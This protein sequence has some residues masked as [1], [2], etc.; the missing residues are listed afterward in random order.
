MSD[1][2]GTVPLFEVS[3]TGVRQPRQRPVSERAR[4]RWSRLKGAVTGLPRDDCMQ[5]YVE[6][7]PPPLLARRAVWRRALGAESRLLCNAHA[8]QWH[9]SDDASSAGGRA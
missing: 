9:A 3:P 1:P 7:T 5:L 4:P 8:E 6:G 2:Y